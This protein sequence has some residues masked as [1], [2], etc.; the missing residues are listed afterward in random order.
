[1]PH[2]DGEL[3]TDRDQAV[4]ALE[5]LVAEMER[6]NHLLAEAGVTKLDQ[7]NRKV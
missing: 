3:I 6:R 1:M 7:F 2:L 4:T 5:E